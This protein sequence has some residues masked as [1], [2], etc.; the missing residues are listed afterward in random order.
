MTN[1]KVRSI[2]KARTEAELQEISA[3]EIGK[4]K[5]PQQQKE[6]LVRHRGW[7]IAAT[8]VNREL[9]HSPTG[10]K[11][12]YTLREAWDCEMAKPEITKGILEN[13]ADP[14]GI[15]PDDMR[16]VDRGRRKN[17]HNK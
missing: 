3:P 9:F 1:P 16:S 2:A 7:Q 8:F 17:R 15:N 11:G 12:L 6:Y 10:Q 14:W 13:N 5:T 4:I